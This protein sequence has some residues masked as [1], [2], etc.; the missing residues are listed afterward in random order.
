MTNELIISN[1][2][3]NGYNVIVLFLMNVI[4]IES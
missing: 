1:L 2:V 4:I 3:T